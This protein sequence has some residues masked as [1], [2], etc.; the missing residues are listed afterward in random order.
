MIVRYEIEHW[1]EIDHEVRT[2][3][4]I[5][6]RGN[7]IGEIVENLYEYFGANNVMT[8]KIYEC[9]DIMCDGELEEIL[10]D[11]T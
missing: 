4:G 7:T 11:N 3:K 10:K 5:T 1:D 2:E 8:L 6:G 9:E